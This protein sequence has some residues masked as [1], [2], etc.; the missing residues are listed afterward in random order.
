MEYLIRK[1]EK[2]DIPAL[3][4]LIKELALFE[5]APNEVVVTIQ[6]L[7]QD[8]FSKNAVFTFFVAETVEKQIVGIA[9][10]YIKYSTWKGKCIFLEDIIV[11]E[12]FR[13]FGIGKKLFLEVVKVAKAIKVKR[14]E[15]QVLN[16]NESAIAFYK[17][18]NAQFDDEWINC[19]LTEEEINNFFSN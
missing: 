17:K 10:Y 8:G 2:Q 3:L 18:L 13:K 6:D 5:K 19:K 9:L 1:G 12:S 16:W 11:K 4:S 15:W 7:E 14:M